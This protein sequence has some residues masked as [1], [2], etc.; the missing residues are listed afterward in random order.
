MGNYLQL[1]IDKNN[2]DNML[3]IVNSMIHITVYT[4]RT[5]AIEYI[6]MCHLKNIE[7]RKHVVTRYYIASRY[8]VVS[9]S[10]FFSTAVRILQVT[11]ES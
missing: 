8:L 6:M 11:M 5:L 3:N 4:T 1:T 7:I 2:I 10:L 9:F